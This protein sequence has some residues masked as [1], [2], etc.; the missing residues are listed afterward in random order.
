MKLSLPS[1]LCA[2]AFGLAL[3][4]A[5][6][7]AD[8][9]PAEFAL[10]KLEN[11]V[12]LTPA[13]RKQ[14]LHIYQNLKDVMD[15]MSPAERPAKGAQSRQDAL[16]AIRG[17][18]TPEQQ[19]IFD[20]APPRLGGGAKSDPVMQALRLK[21]RTFVTDFARTSPEIAAKVGTVKKAVFLATGSMATS[22]GDSDDPAAH[23]ESG[24][25]MVSVTGSSATKT[26]TIFW[27]MNPSG[28]MTVTKV[29]NTTK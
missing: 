26:F 6:S 25:N 17:I 19:A 4:P 13:Q 20:R 27:A 18:L 15:D 2:L 10:E 29:E 9:Q 12:T 3:T 23:P 14:A 8:Y 1:L 7:F 24:T 16:A 28:E 11:L 5:V 21:I 22:N